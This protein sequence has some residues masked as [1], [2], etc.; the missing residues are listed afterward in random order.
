MDFAHYAMKLRLLFFLF[1]LPLLSSAELRLS[2]EARV[3]LMTIGP[4]KEELYSSFG[5]STLWISDPVL[6]LDRSYS[7][8]TFQ[9]DT[10][11]FY[12]K[13]MRG[14][15]PYKITVNPFALEL[16]YYRGENRSVR[17]QEL[18]LSADQ[19]Q[20]LYEYLETNLL[21]ENREYSYKF[22]Y[23]NCSTRLSDALK[24]A[25]G[26]L[27]IYPGYTVE[28][29]SFRQ[30]IDK[31]AYVQKPWA[32]FG[33]DLAIGAP[34]DELATPEQATFLPDNLSEAFDE[35]KIKT[36]SAVVPLVQ[37]SRDLYTATPGAESTVLTPK[38]VFWI[39]AILVATYTFW[40]TKKANIDFTLDKVLFIVVGL[41]GWLILVLWFGTNH[42]VTTWNWDILWACPLWVPFVF[43][44][45][46]RQKPAW[47]Q[48]F[49][50]AYGVLLLSATA[51][52]EKHNYVLIPIL[53][54]L[55]IRVYYLNDT[56]TKIP[57][58]A[59]H[60]S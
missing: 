10:D 33:M 19:K 2:P 45:S 29:R 12:I 8:G 4:G 30:W 17:Q 14:T 48:W 46:K 36:D 22:F 51:I 52:L 1:L 60:E 40:Q 53:L 47:F 21:P 25:V 34:S 26:D 9:F 55:I 28:K 13:F 39:L 50:L 15:L 35:A 27:L 20:R 32:D 38:I 43:M 11:F 24:A 18:N 54:I 16:N 6:Q 31:Y 59:R 41:T 56:L 42:G 37:A 58:V 49:L 23:D 44:F 57:A 7:Y 5:H 3:S